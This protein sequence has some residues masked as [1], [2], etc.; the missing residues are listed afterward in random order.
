[1]ILLT[2]EDFIKIEQYIYD[3]VCNRALYNL[4]QA[5]KNGTLEE[6]LANQSC[7]LYTSNSINQLTKEKELELLKDHIQKYINM[8]V[9]KGREIVNENG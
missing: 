3:V 9:I 1:M 8:G 2:D 5:V 7:L 4:E 6:C